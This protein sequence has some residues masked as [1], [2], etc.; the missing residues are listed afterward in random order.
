[1]DGREGVKTCMHISKIAMSWPFETNIDEIDVSVES[2]SV[3]CIRRCF[4]DFTIKNLLTSAAN[5]KVV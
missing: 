5:P 1:M 2:L 4:W 3:Q